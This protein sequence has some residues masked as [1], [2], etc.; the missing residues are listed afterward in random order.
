MRYNGA[1]ISSKNSKRYLQSVSLPDVPISPED[2]YVRCTPMERLDKVANTYYKDPSMWWII[3]LANNLGKGSLTIPQE[4][5][6]RIP[7]D[8]HSILNKV[9]NKNNGY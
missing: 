5:V 3:A 6:L 7:V 9:N 8:P 2:Y 4:M 1:K